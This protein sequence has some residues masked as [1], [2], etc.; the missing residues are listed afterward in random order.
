MIRMR[1]R[2]IAAWLAV[3]AI[4]LGSVAGSLPAPGPQQSM[5]AQQQPVVST[6]PAGARLVR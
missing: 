5:P 2:F 6:P 1:K 4:A 3:G